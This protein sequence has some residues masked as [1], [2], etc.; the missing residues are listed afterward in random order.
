MKVFISLEPPNNEIAYGGGLFFVKNLKNY[1]INNG[2]TVVYNL[3]H[4]DIDIILIIDPRKGPYKKYDYLELIDYLKINPLTKI[5]Y[6]VNECDIKRKPQSNLEN[7]IHSCINISDNVIF[8]SEWLKNYY[9]NKYRIRNDNITDILPGCNQNIYNN[10]NNKIKDKNKIKLVTHHWSNNYN[11]GFKIYNELDKILIQ[12]PQIEF[13]YIGNYIDSYIPK[14]IKLIKPLVG[15]ELASIIKQND[16]Y[17]TA[18]QYEPGGNHNIEG[19][20]CGLP[21]LYR[22][23]GGSIKEQSEFIGEEYSDIHSLLEK[24]QKIN[25]NYDYYLCNID[26]DKFDSNR[27]SKEYEDYFKKIIK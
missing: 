8:V 11:K 20:S 6:R 1:L 9:L 12:Y 4:N 2:N 25:D 16:I 27:C 10:K 7:V 18:S 21:I 15:E 3:D 26:Y 19:V 14:N 22:T 5:V 23:N 13:T 17:L 24:I